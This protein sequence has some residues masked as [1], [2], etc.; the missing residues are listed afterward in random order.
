MQTC[1][2]FVYNKPFGE[3]ST[4]GAILRGSRIL[5][6]ILRC[7]LKHITFVT[8]FLPCKGDLS[9]HYDFF[10]QFLFSFC[11]NL[12]HIIFNNYKTEINFGIIHSNGF[13]EYQ[14][15][16]FIKMLLKSTFFFNF[17]TFVFVNLNKMW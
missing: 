5:R 8:T 17:V 10:L 7:P 3:M 15:H 4:S 6:S 1:N 16:T 14:S 11:W 2:C 9:W 12:L 13:F